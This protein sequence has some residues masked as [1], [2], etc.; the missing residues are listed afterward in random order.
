ML[1]AMHPD[2]V[3]ER[4]QRDALL[5]ERMRPERAVLLADVDPSEQVVD[6]PHQRVALG[7]ER[8]ALEVE[9]EVAQVGTRQCAE[10]RRRDDLVRRHRR[11][12]AGL[13]QNGLAGAC[14]RAELQPSLRL[15]HRERVGIHPLRPARRGRELVDRRDPGSAQAIPLHG[16]HAG[17][18][19]Q[20]A[21]GHHLRVARGAPAAREHAELT[22]RIAPGD[23][24]TVDAEIEATVGDERAKP[25]AAQAEHR[26]QIVRHVG[27]RRAVA[28]QQLHAIGPLNPQPVELVDVC[29]ELHKRGHTGAPRQLAVL[30]D[31]ASRLV[32]HQEVGESYELVRREGSLVDDVGVRGQCGV[33]AGHGLGE[34]SGIR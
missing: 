13:G 22:A 17:D 33:G 7:V 28:E 12:D 30:H 23:R 16:T 18:E 6:A 14:G 25:R 3:E 15:Q 32:P 11:Q 21:E 19:Q 5:G 26:Q 4:L 10:R 8:V 1:R 29:R 2:E 20:I 34:G 9:E 31:P 27:A 24:R